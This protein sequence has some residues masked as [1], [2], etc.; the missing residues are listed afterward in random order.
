[1]KLSISQGIILL[2][3]QYC[4]FPLSALSS[5][6]QSEQEVLC[7]TAVLTRYQTHNIQRDGLLIV[8]ASL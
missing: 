1:M 5:G 6:L 3:D 7:Q 2:L 4:D 8:T